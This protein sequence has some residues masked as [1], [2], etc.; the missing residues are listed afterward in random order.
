MNTTQKKL[1]T[2]RNLMIIALIAY[3]LGLALSVVRIR[4]L[5]I[6]FYSYTFQELVNDGYMDESTLTPLYLAV[7]TCIVAIIVVS[8]EG[9]YFQFAAVASAILPI[10]TLLG[11][12][13]AMSN[14]EDDLALDPTVDFAASAGYDI[15]AFS[16]IV[17]AIMA[18][19][20]AVKY[21]S[22]ADPE[23]TSTPGH[24]NA[25]AGSRNKM[26]API[27]THQGTSPMPNYPTKAMDPPP[28][29]KVFGSSFC[30]NCGHQIEEGKQ[31][32]TN[33]GVEVEV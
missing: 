14:L 3:I 8:K 1:N 11:L 19:Y 4:F 5:G 17:G 24:P 16:V 13:D 6:T 31:F 7:I 28:E 26:P 27:Y 20:A 10:I 33:C 18:L 29:K 23:K 9:P 15:G 25:M 32:C 12:Q 2:C 22:Q 30:S 21:N